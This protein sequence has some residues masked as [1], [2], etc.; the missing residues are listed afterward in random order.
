MIVR[1]LAAGDH[2]SSGVKRA[3]QRF[4]SSHSSEAEHYSGSIE[5]LHDN[6]V[7]IYDQVDH[8]ADPEM[9]RPNGESGKNRP[10]L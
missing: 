2:P 4:V 5:A 3:L 9:L 8:R 6:R 1:P 7:N 10:R